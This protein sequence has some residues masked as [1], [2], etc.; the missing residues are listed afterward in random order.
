M[1]LTSILVDDEPLA[2]KLIANLLEPISDIEIIG[3]YGTGKEAILAINRLMP[4][5]L[6]VDIQLKDMNG[7]DILQQLKIKMPLVI[8]VTAFDS[9]A[10]EAFN[11]FAFDYLLKPIVEKRFYQSVYRAMETFKSQ[12]N[13]DFDGKMSQLLSHIQR[14]Q[15]EKVDGAPSRIPIPSGN[16][17]VFV[18][19]VDISY[20]LASNYYIEVY[21][22]GSKHLLR[23]SMYSIMSELDPNLFIR[24]HRSSI[25]N[26][27]AVEELITSG[28]GEIDVKMHDGKKLRVSRGYRQGFLLK[29]GLR[30]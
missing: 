29:M 2:R 28:Y 18:K 24:I 11:I 16:K 12:N 7:F 30:K 9:Y 1:K 20:I 26:I 3:Q 8:F 4:D 17:T 23:T 19:P 6:F 22:K 13:Q 5:L 25:I 10:I 21:S 14:G 15:V 27:V